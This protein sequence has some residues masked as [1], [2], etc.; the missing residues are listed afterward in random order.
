GKA[1]VEQTGNIRRAFR[2]LRDGEG[3]EDV[4]SSAALEAMDDPENLFGNDAGETNYDPADTA[5]I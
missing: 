1:T 5:P 2:R 3:V 4:L